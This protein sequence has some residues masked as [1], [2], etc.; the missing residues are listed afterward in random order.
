MA[1]LLAALMTRPPV[2]AAAAALTAT[3]VRQ[4]L[5]A[6]HLRQLMRAEPRRILVFLLLIITQPAPTSA[7]MIDITRCSTSAPTFLLLLMLLQLQ[8]LLLLLLLPLLLLLLRLLPCYCP[9]LILPSII[10]AT[11]LPII[12]PS[13]IIRNRSPIQFSHPLSCRHR[14]VIRFLQIIISSSMW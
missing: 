4:L 5:C 11:L 14:L 10:N 13:P 1:P 2:V 6:Y 8:L 9:I 12:I 7:S 3:A